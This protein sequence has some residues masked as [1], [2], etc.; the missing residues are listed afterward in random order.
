MRCRQQPCD[1]CP[2]R[3]DTPRGQFPPER[4]EALRGTTGKP[5]AE[6]PLGARMFQ[7]HKSDSDPMPC[8]GWL[9]AVGYESLTVRVLVAQG[10]IPADRLASRADWPALHASYTELEAVHGSRPG[11]GAS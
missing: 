11:G 2:W 4:Y 5:G 10:E 8:A 3:R 7:C 6:A 1:E 9:A